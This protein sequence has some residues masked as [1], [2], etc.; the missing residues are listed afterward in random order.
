VPPPPKGH[1]H[2]KKLPERI[3]KIQKA[4]ENQE[5]RIAEFQKTRP[6]KVVKKG[7]RLVMK[8]NPWEEA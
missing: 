4:L 5:Q 8:K 2:D 6:P 3:A 1:K 7:F